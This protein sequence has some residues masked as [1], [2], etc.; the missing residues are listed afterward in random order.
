MRNGSA[1]GYGQ[2]TWI[3]WSEIEQARVRRGEDRGAEEE[4]EK[5]WERSWSEHEQVGGMDRRRVDTGL[6]GR[7]MIALGKITQ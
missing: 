2:T 1:A 5:D 4:R 6:D 3:L 7:H